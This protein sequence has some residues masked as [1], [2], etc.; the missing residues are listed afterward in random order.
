[1]GGL[2]WLV[3]A[4]IFWLRGGTVADVHAQAPTQPAGQVAPSP[5]QDSAS[6]SE[7]KDRV[8]AYCFDERITREDLGEYLIARY[9]A[10]KLD[11]LVNKR[12]IEHVCKEHHIE[13]S[14][15]EVNA[16]LADDLKSLNVSSKDFVEKFLKPYKKNLYEWKEDVIRPKLMMTR[17][18]HDKVVYSEADI[19]MCYDA[20]YGEKVDGRLIMWPR[21]ERSQVFSLYPSIRDSDAEF[22]RR[23][24]EQAS[25][26]LAA[27]GGK[28]EKPIGH[29]TTGNDVLESKLFAL[30]PGEISD[31]I[32]A[33]EG[34]VVF[35][36]DAQHP[37][38]YLGELRR[39]K[40]G[41]GQGSDREKDPGGDR[42][43]VQ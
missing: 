1:M 8:V 22:N 16:A 36:C 30:Q 12:I 28:L 6:S 40:A 35:K 9:G 15:A 39:E 10:E 19:R 37:T 4:G 32:E 27:R 25:A 21:S 34:V 41:P 43:G 13:V 5:S 33:P 11:L 20:Y 14:T 3:A 42:Q 24:K 7:Y 31:V 2:G 26:Q 17:L 18:V 38:R 29:H 23:A